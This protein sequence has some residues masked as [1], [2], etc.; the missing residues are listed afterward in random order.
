ML[1]FRRPAEHP[2]GEESAISCSVLHLAVYLD[3][4]GHQ[5]PAFLDLPHVQVNKA[6][7]KDRARCEMAHT[8]RLAVGSSSSLSTYLS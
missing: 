6:F 8:Q 3:M 4:Q 1:L 5:L 7:S 2:S